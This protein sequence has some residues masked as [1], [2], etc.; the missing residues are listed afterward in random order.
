MTEQSDLY[1][2]LMEAARAAKDPYYKDLFLHAAAIINAHRSGG[3]GIGIVLVAFSVM[4]FVI[5]LAVG[6]VL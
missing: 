3:A 4:S 1:V 5:G 6:L 2:E